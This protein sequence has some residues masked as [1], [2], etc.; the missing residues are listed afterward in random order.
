MNYY[1]ITVPFTAVAGLLHLTDAQADA[2]KS[3]LDPVPG[4]PGQPGQY[5][6]R[7]AVG[8]KAGEVFGSA[9]EIQG[10][11]RLEMTEAD[12]AKAIVAERE[13]AAARKAAILKA[14]ADREAKIKA[15][16]AQRQKDKEAKA[17]A[18]RKAQAGK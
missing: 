2:R 7:Q 18:I 14:R 17:A 4:Q 13:D 9:G 16:A 1:R 11:E 5:A 12:F 15:V 10:A 3:M 6:T 8:F